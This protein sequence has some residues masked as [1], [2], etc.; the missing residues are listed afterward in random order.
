MSERITEVRAIPIRVP[1]DTPYL[2]Q[3]EAGV[4]VSDKGYFVR[5]GNRS[6]YSI[7]DQSTLVRIECSS[8]A[9][10]WGEC[11]S[12]VVPEVA[13]QII[14]DVIG[15]YLVGRDPQDPAVLYHDLYDLMRV[16]GYFGGYYHDAIAAV[17]IALWDLAARLAGLPLC[18]L[19]GGQRHA[20]LPA[21]VSGL[22]RPSLDQRVELARAWQ[23]KGFNAFKFASAVSHEGTAV[24]MQRLREAL[25][26]SAVIL[27]DMHWKHTAPEAIRL[28]QEMQR[29]NLAV[30]EAPCHPE[31]IEGQALVA[32]G[33]AVPVGLGEELRTVFEFLPRFE[34]RSMGVIQPEMGRTG[35]TAFMEI[36]TLARAFHVAVMPHAS[37]GIGLF[38]A[39]SLHASAVLPHLQMHEYQHSIFDKNLKY[40]VGDMRCAEG[41]FYLP[42]GPG[43]GVVPC[44]QLLK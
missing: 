1:R 8:G 9:V 28:I 11:V 14:G 42:T 21:Y 16:R 3:L 7:H 43:L 39:A 34:R 4:S 2:G 13:A 26:P 40:I 20:S 41:R 30:A 44:E 37:I 10:G 6:V 5:P 24:E 27:C 38:Q 25:G 36:C 35:V 33:V 18:K 22:P 31:D 17:D 15:P 23:A 29:W 12:F 19:L 32:R